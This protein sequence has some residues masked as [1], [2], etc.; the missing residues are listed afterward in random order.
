MNKKLI[1]F[2]ALP[3]TRD[4]R[5]VRYLNTEG[6]EEVKLN[7]WED[8]SNENDGI[9]KLKLDKKR[10]SKIITYP[11]Y[12]LYLFFYSLFYIKNDE[13]VICMELDTFLPVYLGSWFKNNT[14]Y[15]DIVDPI[16]ETKF[17]AFPFN[18]IFDYLEVI[19][20]KYRKYNI[21]PNRNRVNYYEEKLGV[22]TQDFNY[23]IVENVPLLIADNFQ[24]DL[25]QNV[26]IG[27][28]GTLEESRGLMEL[29][30]FIQKV[31]MQLIIAGDGRLKNVI[32][33]KIKNLNNI[34]YIGSFKY[35]KIGDLFEKIDFLWAYYSDK[36]FL[37]KFA[38]PNKYYEHLAYK[39]PI[40]MNKFVPQS[41]NIRKNNSGIVIGDDLTDKTFQS[42]FFAMKGY[43]YCKENFFL[44]E[45]KYLKYKIILKKNQKCTDES[46]KV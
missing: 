29:I 34:K 31:D 5:T 1:V 37:H 26:T 40:I 18:I 10:Y 3:K 33:E 41:I 28:F 17:K 16:A 20:L 15:F 19:F 21:L 46:C 25:S 42:L 38:S 7:T 30:N 23:A 8:F 32:I 45:A 35:E 36:V 9:H 4:A 44:W 13:D 14:I 11:L 6:Y 27:Y 43:R 39:T 12:L 24:K 22:R 2:R